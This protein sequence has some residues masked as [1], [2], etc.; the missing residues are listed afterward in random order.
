MTPRQPGDHPNERT[1]RR[2]AS[3]Y[4][5]LASTGLVVVWLVPVFLVGVRNQ[6]VP[7]ANNWMQQQYRVACLFLE[8][9]PTWDTYFVQVQPVGSNAWVELDRRGIFDMTVFGPR[10]RLH[11]ILDETYQEPKG[12]L[13]MEAIAEFFRTRYDEQYPQGPKLAA[14]RF[15]SV[16][17]PVSELGRETGAF[18]TGTLADWAHRNWLVFGEKRWDGKKPTH[19]LWGAIEKPARRGKYLKPPAEAPRPLEGGAP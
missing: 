1:P 14:L 2:L 19:P 8:S 17:R 9:I 3:W 12:G 10:S 11:A 18:W 13:R 16:A 6:N 15:V 5:W 7:F 4:D